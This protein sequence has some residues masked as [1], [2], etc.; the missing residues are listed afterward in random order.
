M[1]KD[2]RV[3]A[4]P[5]EICNKGKLLKYWFLHSAAIIDS[6]EYAISSIEFDSEITVIAATTEGKAEG[7]AFKDELLK[8]GRILKQLSYSPLAEKVVT[9]ISAP[10]LDRVPGGTSKSSQARAVQALKDFS[11]EPAAPM[12]NK[13]S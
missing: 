1:T 12:P 6:N 10:N 13:S 3:P 4:I 11:L 2:P 5:N 7:V 8:I 9:H